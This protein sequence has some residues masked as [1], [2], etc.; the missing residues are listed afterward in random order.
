MPLTILQNARWLRADGILEEGELFLREGRVELHRGG[1]G[2]SAARSAPRADARTTLDARG[3]LVLPG[4]IDAH[5]HFRDPGQEHKEDADSGSRAALAGGVTTVLD[6]PN[7][8]PPIDTA[9]RL[10]RKADRFRARCHVNWGLHLQASV[11]QPLPARRIASAKVYMAR[12]SSRPAIGTQSELEAIFARYPRVTVHAEDEG[13]FLPADRARLHQHARPRAAIAS[14][15]ARVEAALRSLPPERRPRVVLCHAST[16]EE[17]RWLARMKAE[18]FDLWGE[19][20]PHYLLLT[21]ED[22]ARSGPRLQVNPPL[23]TGGDRAA[24]LAAL[25]DGTLDFVSTDHAPHAP[26]E[27][28]SERPPS[29]I[30]GIEWM[31]PLLLQLVERGELGWR[32]LLEVGASQAARCYGLEGRG[33]VRDSGV[34][35]LVLAR[36]APGTPKHPLYT[37]AGYDA[38]A[39]LALDWTVEATFVGGRLAWRAGDPALGRPPEFA[40]GLRG[41]EL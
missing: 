7:N 18:R 36:R 27:K 30:P 1:T 14:A 20:C 34:A 28:A 4:L 25:R 32:R 13:H 21:E 2:P 10:E 35:D 6:M 38:Y 40:E 33:G 31:L 5:T 23:R 41:E 26:A 17:V 29:G 22:Y 19:T 11:D 37:R 16:V 12:S 3:A 39:D 24:L 8:E 9:E 15:L